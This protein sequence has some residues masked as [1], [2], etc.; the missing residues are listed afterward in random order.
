MREILF[1]GK[2]TDNGEWVYGD[3]LHDYWLQGDEF[4]KCAIRY[5][6]GEVYSFPIEVDECTICQFTGLLDKNGKKIFEGDLLQQWVDD[7]EA[8]DEEETCPKKKGKIDT[9]TM[10]RFPCYWL[11]DETFGYEGDELESPEDWEIIGN[12]HDKTATT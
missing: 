2:R 1:R 3:L 8:W 12:I 4:I 9:A 6:I 5:K 7:W 11:A 10:E